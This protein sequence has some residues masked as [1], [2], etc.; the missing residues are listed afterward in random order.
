MEHSETANGGNGA[1]SVVYRRTIDIGRHPAL[2]DALADRV[3][4]R[5][6]LVQ[7]AG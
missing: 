6:K 7:Y 2:A 3:A 5:V 4:L 1:E